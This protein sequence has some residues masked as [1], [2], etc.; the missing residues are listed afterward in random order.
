MKK[1]I[2]ILAAIAVLSCKESENKALEKEVVQV[3][4]KDAT[5][6]ITPVLT[7]SI[8]VRA[9]DYGNGNY[10]YAG[11]KGSYGNIDVTTGSP[12]RG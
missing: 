3:I 11:S 7:D 12:T 6:E 4:A 1:I 9:L 10:W 5:I 8:S 2:Y